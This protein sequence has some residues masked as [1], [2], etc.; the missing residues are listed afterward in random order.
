MQARQS[1]LPYQHKG[2]RV[3]IQYFLFGFRSSLKPA[4]PAIVPPNLPWR[5]GAIRHL[6]EIRHNQL[7]R[8]HLLAI[9]T[10]DHPESRYS[11]GRLMLLRHP[12]DKS[13]ADAARSYQELLL[14][15]D[16]TFVD[17]PL[18]RLADWIATLDLD[19]GHA[20]WLDALR[21]RYLD[22]A[23]S[24]EAFDAWAGQR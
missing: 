22:L 4:L 6:L 8:D 12:G 18:N 14:P 20:A 3:S 19:D 16:G 1:V 23:A 15:G 5:E 7:W 10:L 9:A 24:Q 11:R 2:L 13:C 21:L 17:M